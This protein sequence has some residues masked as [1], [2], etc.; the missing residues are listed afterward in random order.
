MLGSG[1]ARIYRQAAS[2][3]KGCFPRRSKG[4]YPS[5]LIRARF[6]C[7]AESIVS[8]VVSSSNHERNRDAP[9][10]NYWLYDVI[11]SARVWPSFQSIF[12]RQGN[13]RVWPRQLLI[14]I[15]VVVL[16]AVAMSHW[17][18]VPYAIT[19]LGI[20]AWTAFGHLITLDDDIPGKWS[21]PEGSQ[22]VWRQSKLALVVKFIVFIAFFAVISLVPEITAFGG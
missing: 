14:T 20:L 5:R 12:C 3:K 11:L 2:A 13:M 6:Q 17:F 19:V 16:I 15:L 10:P 8:F 18:Q 21:N 1:I 7:N 4:S 22:V 9:D